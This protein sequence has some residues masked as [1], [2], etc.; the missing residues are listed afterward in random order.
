MGLIN[1]IYGPKD[2]MMLNSKDIKKMFR[3]YLMKL[4]LESTVKAVAVSLAAGLVI[5]Q[6]G[7]RP[8]Q[9]LREAAQQS[10]LA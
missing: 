8:R 7:P 2:E 1:M 3:P 4:R 6:I 10:G 9:S 5:Q